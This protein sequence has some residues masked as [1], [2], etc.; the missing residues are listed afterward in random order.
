M[1]E[2]REGGKKRSHTVVF[3]TLLV[4]PKTLNLSTLKP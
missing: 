2:A 3:V 4:N 1:P